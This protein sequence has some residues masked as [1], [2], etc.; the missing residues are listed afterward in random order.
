MA[1]DFQNRFTNSCKLSPDGHFGSK[2]VT[3]VVTGK[4]GLNDVLLPCLNLAWDLSI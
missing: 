4:N 2:F 1:A 3:V